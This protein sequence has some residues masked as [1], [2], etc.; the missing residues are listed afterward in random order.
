MAIEYPSEKM[1][2][3]ERAFWYQILVLALPRPIFQHR[4]HATRK[5]RVDFAYM[6]RRIAIEI[7]GVGRIRSDKATGVKYHEKCC[8]TCGQK[9]PSA[10]R[11]V[12]GYEND[13]EKYNELRIGGWL[14]LQFTTPMVNDGRA[15]AVLE[16]VLAGTKG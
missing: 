14:H 11:T 7:E 6:D 8:P 2:D 3:G 9:P 13:V 4:F 5:W 10:H 16:R 1:S 15:I 12:Q